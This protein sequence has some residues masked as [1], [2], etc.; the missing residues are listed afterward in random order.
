[1]DLGLHYWTFSASGGPQRIPET[2]AAAA[3]TAEE[4]SFAELSVMDHYLQ[5]EWRPRAGT[6][7]TGCMCGV[8]TPKWKDATTAASARP[9]L[10]LGRCLMTTRPS[11]STLIL[12]GSGCLTVRSDFRSR[13]VE[14]TKHL[15]TIVPRLAEIR[16][17][18]QIN[19]SERRRCQPGDLHD[20]RRVAR[21]G[22]REVAVYLQ[23]H[24]QLAGQRFPQ[25]SGRAAVEQLLQRAR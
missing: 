23:P 15:A 8:Q 21:R 13:P 7:A 9:P 5:T 10:I 25:H 2:L 1:M 6:S 12:C 19:F 3:K 17:T 11:F 4:A 22:E 24:G 16:R 20:G 18:D 14:Y